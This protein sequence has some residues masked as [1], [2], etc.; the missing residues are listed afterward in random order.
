MNNGKKVRDA[1]GRPRL[2]WPF[3]TLDFEAS[4]LSAASYPIEVGVCVWRHPDEPIAGWSTLI[5]PS[6]AWRDR[7]EWSEA[8]AAVHRIPREALGAGVNPA[9]AMVTLNAILART[10]GL[11]WC[12]G[13]PYDLF[14]LR[15]LEAAA[16]VQAGFTLGDIDMLTARFSPTEFLRMDRWFARAPARHRARDDAE[17][18][19]KGLARAVGIRHGT[20]VDLVVPAADGVRG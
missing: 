6:A 17:R 1:A 18:L 2:P 7:G 9:D 12:D 19:V 20:P 14:W 15:R 4:A 3:A 16:R 5:R 8:S 13:G 10:G 11:A